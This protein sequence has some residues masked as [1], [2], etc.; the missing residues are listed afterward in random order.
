MTG[1]WPEINPFPAR[2]EAALRRVLDLQRIDPAEVTAAAWQIFA[3]SELGR[4]DEHTSNR[5]ASR[6]TSEEELR[7]FHDLCGALADHIEA[8]HNPAIAA[9][10][11]EGLIARDLMRNLQAAQETARCAFGG[12]DDAPSPRGRPPKLEAAE[13]T[14]M[15]A[16]YY[17]QFT[18]R[19]PTFATDPQSHEVSGPWID[20]LHAVFEALGIR[21]KVG[22]QAKALRKKIPAERWH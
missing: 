14:Q 15:T 1:P 22:S 13:V 21:A 17:R 19:A 5:P 2:I 16:I 20:T 7:T 12:L 3:V 11:Q 10:S 8:M 18:G 4:S 9:L 6:D